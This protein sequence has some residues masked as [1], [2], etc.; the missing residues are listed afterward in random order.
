M[1]RIPE[2]L[3]I[4]RIVHIENVPNEDGKHYK[5][6]SAVVL[7]QEGDYLFVVFTTRDLNPRPSKVPVRSGPGANNGLPEKCMV[8]GHWR[9]R[10]HKERVAIVGE[11]VSL[12]ELRDIRGA[13]DRSI[14]DEQ[15]RGVGSAL[16]FTGRGDNAEASEKL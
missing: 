1:N 15:R 9:G 11:F 13:V 3:G 7:E 2:E 5:R 4:G 6:R 10:V 16:P 12:N 14:S 8:V